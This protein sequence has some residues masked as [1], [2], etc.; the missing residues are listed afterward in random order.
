MSGHIH[1]FA[2]GNGTTKPQP[3]DD[4]AE[5]VPAMTGAPRSY[6]ALWDKPEDLMPYDITLLSCEGGET[7]NAIPANLETYLNAGGRVIASHFQ[8]AWFSGPLASPQTYKAPADWGDNLAHWTTGATTNYGPIGGVVNQTL[9]GSTMPFVK[10]QMLEQWLTHVGAMVTAKTYGAGSVAV[11][12]LAIYDPRYN[13]A[14]ATPNKPSQPWITSDGSGSGG[15]AGQ[16]MYFSFDTPIGAQTPCGRGVFSD[17]HVGG[18]YM[19][20]DMAPAPAGCST[21][22][23]QGTTWMPDAGPPPAVKL[24]AQ[25]DALEFMIYDLSACVALDSIAPPPPV[26][27]LA[28]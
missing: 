3:T 15:V 18:S 26:V 8:Y 22:P 23:I 13:A 10:G 17:L 16:T 9:N 25:E 21:G 1:L 12:D 28:Q 5:E 27:P 20:K 11:G 14:V 19:T 7:Y 6:A 24:S 4:G 2:G